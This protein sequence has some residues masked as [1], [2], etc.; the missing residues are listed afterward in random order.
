MTTP[1]IAK[2]H[3]RLSEF[4]NEKIQVVPLYVSH[5]LNTIKKIQ[6]RKGALY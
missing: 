1:K 4:H 6:F 3:D 5:F 2:Q